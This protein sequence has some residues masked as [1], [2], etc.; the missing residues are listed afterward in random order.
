MS[1]SESACMWVSR[2]THYSRKFLTV[3]LICLHLNQYFCTVMKSKCNAL[4]HCELVCNLRIASESVASFTAARC[5]S[6]SDTHRPLS[7]GESSGSDASHSDQRVHVD[8]SYCTAVSSWSQWISSHWL[9]RF[10][11]HLQRLTAQHVGWWRDLYTAAS[12]RHSISITTTTTIVSSSNSSSSHD[13]SHIPQWHWTYQR[14]QQTLE[15]NGW[16]ISSSVITL[17]TNAILTSCTGGRHNMLPPLVTLI[18]YL[19]TSKVV[20]ESRV[21][22][23]TSVPILVFLGLCSRL[24]PDVRDRRQTDRCQTASLLNAPA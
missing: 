21:T 19:L 24:R 13:C 9:S 16:T 14:L 18:F 3:A 6:C 7:A 20:S 12:H 1:V 23:A 22:W 15:C 2:G 5:V 10:K 17:A 11:R 4:L 8:T